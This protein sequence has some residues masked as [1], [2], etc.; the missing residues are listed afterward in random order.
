[1]GYEISPKDL[2]MEFSKPKDTIYSSESGRTPYDI[3]CSGNIKGI[4]FAV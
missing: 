1:M 2:Q 3:L 4:K